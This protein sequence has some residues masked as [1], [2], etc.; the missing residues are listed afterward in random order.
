MPASPDLV[1]RAFEAD[2]P[3][4]I[5]VAD[6]TYVPTWAGFLFLVVVID[7]WSRIEA[8]FGSPHPAPL[9]EA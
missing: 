3:D 7:V 2:G 6:I 9:D 5:W 8:E 1:A 4:K